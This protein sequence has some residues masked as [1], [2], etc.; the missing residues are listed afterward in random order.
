[1]FTKRTLEE[2][3]F[4]DEE[5]GPVIARRGPGARS[6]SIRVTPEKILLRLPAGIAWQ[7]GLD[8]LAKK[9]PWVLRARQRQEARVE[10]SGTAGLSDE[11]KKRRIL[12]MRREAEVW[13]RAKMDELIRKYGFKVNTV[14]L[15]LLK[16][17]W[18][19]CSVR[20]NINININVMRLPEDCR[21]YVLLHE[22]SHL[23]FMN[24]GPKFHA[25][26][27]LLCI[28]ETGRSR[29]DLEREIRG[30]TMLSN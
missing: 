17:R 2:K 5:L 19:S 1:M 13:V 26:L 22:L 29:L 10:N 11:E 9:R 20:R 16:S 28:N 14:R 18:G 12:E 21:T 24:H 8:F 15:K 30:Y 25:F 4:M 23:L 6:V 3:I 27:E 7:R